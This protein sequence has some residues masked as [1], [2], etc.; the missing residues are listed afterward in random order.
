MLW[1]DDIVFLGSSDD[2]EE[3]PKKADNKEEHLLFWNLLKT[4]RDKIK[5]VEGAGILLAGDRAL[6]THGASIYVSAKK[7]SDGSWKLSKQDGHDWQ[8]I[9][10]L[11]YMPYAVT[12]IK[13][14]DYEADHDFFL[15]VELSGC[16]FT[17]TDTSVLHIAADAGFGIG[18]DSEKR[19]RAEIAAL[20]GAVPR[21][22]RSVSVTERLGSTLYHARL[23][24]ALAAN[25]K[26]AVLA[27]WPGD[28]AATGREVADTLANYVRPLSASP[29]T[30]DKAKFK[31][32]ELAQGRGKSL[33]I[34]TEIATTVEAAMT[35]SLP[36]VNAINKGAFIFGIKTEGTWAYRALINGTWHDITVP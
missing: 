18:T 23:G 34:A 4:D 33:D 3:L 26:S 12:C 6:K 19:D 5:K 20:E 25:A 22:R 2:D 24:E 36:T 35:T 7:I 31:L 21:L 29:S 30:V 10:L 1:D 11:N 17:I 27:A 16:R 28:D 15:T 8:K 32:I 14:T 13:R 9:Y